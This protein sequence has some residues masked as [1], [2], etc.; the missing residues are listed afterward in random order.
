MNFWKVN[1]E[2]ARIK[3]YD[4]AWIWILP[5][6]RVLEGDSVHYFKEFNGRVYYVGERFE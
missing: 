1:L 2:K 3:W 6:Y 4:W 5:T